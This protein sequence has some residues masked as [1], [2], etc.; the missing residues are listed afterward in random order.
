[1]SLASFVASLE[2][3][4]FEDPAKKDD[5]VKIREIET[6]KDA[7]PEAGFIDGE[8]AAIHVDADE[9]RED[10]DKAERA[11]AALEALQSELVLS[12]EEGGLSAQGAR[13]AALFASQYVRETGD[14]S[15]VASVE[16][17]GGSSSRFRATQI[18]MEGVG[19]ALK[20]GWKA[21][22]ELL[23]KIGTF[24]AEST[25][26]I[27]FAAQRIE[28]KAKKLATVAQKTK[29]TNGKIDI[30]GNSLLFTNGKLVQNGGTE[31]AAAAKVIYQAYPEAVAQYIA[32][33]RTAAGQVKSKE[34]LA[35]FEKVINDT[36]FFARV[37]SKVNSAPFSTPEG[38]TIL[39]TRDMP[40][41]FALY[42]V[43]VPNSMSESV[44]IHFARAK[45]NKTPE[46]YEVTARSSSVIYAEM[47]KIAGA[48]RTIVS[49]SANAKKLR[50]QVD[51]AA[52][53]LE[54]LPAVQGAK[55]D[56]A[57]YKAAKKLVGSMRGLIGKQYTGTRLHLI[58][59]LAAQVKFAAKELKAD[60]QGSASEG[61][62]LGND[63]R[64]D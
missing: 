26:R 14:E 48:A 37:G 17:F 1:M 4:N 63:K 49:A 24:I 28:S 15:P 46:S 23:K 47:N 58:R 9:M 60:D 30:G 27:T 21:F 12:M 41:D 6:E 54:S 20:K 50:Q 51:E 43:V 18:S 44:G 13:M 55:T 56:D 45:G 64:V 29:V 61:N 22:I 59:A 3:D 31:L 52:K 16:A 32:K 10:G 33:A 53:L 36:S 39:K 34:D 35:S 25:Q 57:S 42:C 38:A 62:M 5:D 8:E 7:V 40:G 19:E 11:M 2:S